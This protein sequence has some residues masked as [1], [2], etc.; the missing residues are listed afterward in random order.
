MFNTTDS[1]NSISENM[2]DI[3]KEI[4]NICLNC[5]KDTL[6]DNSCCENCEM[7]LFYDILIKANKILNN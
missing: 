1:I 5:D 3:F 7:R 2:K 6:E 4:D